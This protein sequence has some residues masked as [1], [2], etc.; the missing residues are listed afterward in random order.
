MVTKTTT[1][2]L[3]VGAGPTGLA[4]ACQLRGQGIACR[5]IDKNPH[6]STTSKALALQYRVS[7]VLACMG[8]ADRFLA[9]GASWVGEMTFHAKGEEILR[10]PMNA[11][12]KRSG[13]DAFNPRLLVI[14]QSETEA[15]LEETLRER[16]GLV[17]RNTA[18]I[19][20]SQDN[21]Q[22]VSHLQR[23]DGHQEQVES[24][25]LVSCEGAHSLIRKQ[26]G[27]TFK[28]KTYPRTFFMADVDLDWALGR[29]A[30]H[31]WLHNDGMFTAIPM[32]G[33]RQWRLFVDS[34]KKCSDGCPTEVNLSFMQQL[35][36]ERTGDRV[37]QVT[38]PTWLTEFKINCRMVDRFRQGRVFL[39]GDAAHIHSPSG[40]QGITTGVQDAYNLAWKLSQ[41]LRAGAPDSLLDTYQEERVPIARAVLKTTDRNTQLLMTQS[42]VGK[43]FRDYVVLPLLRMRW[44]LDRLISRL[45]QLDMH[46]RPASL[47]IHQDRWLGSG[48]HIR[49]GD[50]TPDIVFSNAADQ[51]TSLFECLAKGR[52]VALVGSPNCPDHVNRVLG[53]L[54]RLGVESFLL[55][56]NRRMPPTAN[57]LIDVHGDFQR[58]FGAKGEFL[59]LIRPDGHVGLFQRPINERALQEYL[60]KLYPASAVAEGFLA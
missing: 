9:R 8:I 34:G 60:L 18:F 58:I 30:A 41:V 46:Y 44:V 25:Y 39:A 59:Y 51:R 14:P 29:Q 52:L 12:G 22:V 17:E 47:S 13:K 35:L 31:V 1:D 45:S 15:I 3:I 4:L 36:I 10:L 28:G 57:R 26:A 49:A 54:R 40:G 2:V 23:P 11:I 32:G 37:T 19:E 42:P 6:A 16:G 27:F 55:G 20:F 38:N 21:D 50:R 33:A 5:I 48:V 43:L 24:K 53:A 56:S 7:E